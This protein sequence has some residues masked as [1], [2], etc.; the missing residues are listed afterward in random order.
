MKESRATASL[1]DRAHGTIKNRILRGDVRLGDAISR[2]KLASE[3]GMSFLPVSLALLRLEYEGFVESRPRAGT[4]VRI[5][6]RDDIRG[7][8]VV[9]EALEVQAARLFVAAATE[10]DVADLRKMALVLDAGEGLDVKHLRL[11]QRFHKRIADVAGCPAL[12]ATIEQVHALESTWLC[13]AEPQPRP[14]AGRRHQDLMDALD[15]KDPDQAAE[16]VRQHIDGGVA[17]V[18]A[19]LKRYF[20]RRSRTFVRKTT[21]T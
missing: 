12:A 16:A 14:A 3:L 8:Y 18:M 11:H 1:M 9:R 4:R 2:R 13:A 19:G 15:R 6:S 7:H 21:T 10:E 17:M 5:P 20:A